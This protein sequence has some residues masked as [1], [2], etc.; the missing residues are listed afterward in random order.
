M[1]EE[2]IKHVLMLCCFFFV[3]YLSFYTFPLITNE[4]D[5]WYCQ[6]VVNE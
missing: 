6:L 4:V 5:W 1:M 2:V 3:E